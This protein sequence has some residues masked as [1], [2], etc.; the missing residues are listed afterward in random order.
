MDIYALLALE[1]VLF[2]APGMAAFL[3]ISVVAGVCALRVARRKGYSGSVLFWAWLP[4]GNIC[5]LAAFCAM[6]DLTLRAKIE[7]LT[8]KTAYPASSPNS[9]PSGD[10]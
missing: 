2:L 9:A 5:A 10:S 6:P 7:S 3:V 1:S 8:A 4:V